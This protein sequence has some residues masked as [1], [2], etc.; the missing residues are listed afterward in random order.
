MD[1]R[2][3]RNLK[4]GRQVTS[5]ENMRLESLLDE[6]ALESQMAL[7]V[8]P[9]LEKARKR[10]RLRGRITLNYELYPRKD[11]RGTIVISHGFTE[12]CVKY[13]ELI[14]Y[15]HRQGYQIAILDHRGHG[16]SQRENEDANTVY[17]TWFEQYVCNL[18]RFVHL[19]VKPRLLRPGMMLY[20][21][22]HSMGGC[23]GARYL[24]I[25][26]DD[27][28]KAVL[29]APMLGLKLGVCPSWAAALLC[30]IQILAGRGKERLFYQSPFSGEEPFERSSAG[31]RAR[32][33]Y[34]QKIRCRD[35][36]YQ[37]SSASYRWAREAIRAGRRAVSRREAGKVTAR[38]LLFQAGN[39][40]LVTNRAQRLFLKR[41]AAGTLIRVPAAR[42]EIYRSANRI[43]V[44]Y[45][46]AVID[47]YG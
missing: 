38:V 45:L 36:D 9:Y 18:H 1:I 23:I 2:H 47:F 17:V 43:L 34:Y 29:N 26:P 7:R 32:H 3:G 42:H 20:L 24:E 12:S 35:Q 28:Q 13:Y 31:S 39:D 15:L 19:V 33:A 4:K 37:T 40:T 16:K 10:G 14:Y 6:D 8:E 5:D 44:S 46:K 25:W 30:D 22:G 41:I 21:Y 11:A 27:F